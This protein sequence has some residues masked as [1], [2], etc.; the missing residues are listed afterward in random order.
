MREKMV[1][2]SDDEYLALKLGKNELA[3]LG[4]NRLPDKKMCSKCG[5]ELHGFAIEFHHS[6]CPNCGNQETG[7]WI[8]AAGGFA[9]GALAAIGIGALIY[10][11]FK[12]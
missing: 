7:F 1:R 12:D 6:K 3:K 5:E 4:I 8:T 9:L 2:M 10:Y 11:L